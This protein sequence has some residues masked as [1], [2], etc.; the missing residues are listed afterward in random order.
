MHFFIFTNILS[1]KSMTKTEINAISA[2]CLNFVKASSS[3]NTCIEYKHVYMTHVDILM[4]Y[5]M[6]S[7][8]A[9]LEYGMDHVKIEM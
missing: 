2:P 3:I 9:Q 6:V 8:F 1:K 4:C 7:N 5:F